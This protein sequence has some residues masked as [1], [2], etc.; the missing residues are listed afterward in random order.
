MTTMEL[1]PLL[2]HQP[3]TTMV[4]QLQL[5]ITTDHL[6]LQMTTM[7][8]QPL[9]LPMTTMVLLVDLAMTTMTVMTI[10]STTP[11][12]SMMEPMTIMVLQLLQTITMDHL[13][14]HSVLLQP[15]TM[16]QAQPQLLLPV[17]DL[18]PALVLQALALIAVEAL[19]AAIL[20]LPAL[21]APILELPHK[22]VP[23]SS[24]LAEA[25]NLSKI[26]STAMVHLQPTPSPTQHLP[27]TVMV[28]PQHPLSTQPLTVMALHQPQ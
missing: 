22:Q 25:N 7:E 13:P 5:T 20:D 18:V 4:L 12:L 17:M 21:S 6:L 11:N 23:P 14:L 28:L 15:Q 9:P 10:M 2:L 24:Q 27:Q 19:S 1:Q 3:M 26:T 16:E 8:L